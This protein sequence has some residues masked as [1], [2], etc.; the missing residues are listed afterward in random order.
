V[1]KAYPDPGPEPER[2]SPKE[3]EA[4]RQA[5]EKFLMEGGRPGVSDLPVKIDPTDKRLQTLRTEHKRFLELHSPMKAALWLALLRPEK[6]IVHDAEMSRRY[7]EAQR[8]GYDGAAHIAPDR[9]SI[10]GIAQR[11]V[12]S[13][14][15]GDVAAIDR[16]ADRIEGKAGLRMGDE[17]EGDP[18]KRKQSTD[19][20]ER[21]IRQLTERRI[22]DI[23][24]TRGDKV[25]DVVAT[26][27]VKES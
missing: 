2:A 9:P 23:T 12:A 3:R 13:A 14:L 25:I 16:I 6:D 7:A 22:A 21:V 15:A 8:M 20:T 4:W 26:E 5:N 17:D 10:I 24:H 11:L 27:V 19:I 1:S 18:A